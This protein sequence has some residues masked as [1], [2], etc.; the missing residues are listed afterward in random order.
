MI[1][2]IELNDYEFTIGESPAEQNELAEKV[3]Q[4]TDQTIT[5]SEFADWVREHIR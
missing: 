1:L 2:F 5:E 4:V 3:E